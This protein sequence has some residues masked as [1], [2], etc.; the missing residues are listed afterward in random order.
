MRVRG[1]SFIFEFNVRSL[2]FI[3]QLL[4]VQRELLTSAEPSEILSGR[5]DDDVNDDPSRCL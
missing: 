5:R 2:K 3:L 4:R 1:R